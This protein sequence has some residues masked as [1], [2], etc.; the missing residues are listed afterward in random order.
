MKSILTIFLVL[1][2]SASAF[3]IV[4]D[5]QYCDGHLTNATIL[6]VEGYGSCCNN[7]A[8]MPNRYYKRKVSCMKCDVHQASTFSFIALPGSYTVD[9]PLL[10]TPSLIHSVI[11]YSALFPRNSVKQQ[12]EK[13]PLFLLHQVFRI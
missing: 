13:P 2:Y 12:Y 4:V 9:I 8:E 1:I 11:F 5:D 3:G 7:A 6:S 10:P